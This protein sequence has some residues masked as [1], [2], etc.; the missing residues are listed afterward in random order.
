[1]LCAGAAAA[2]EGTAAQQIASELA[3]ACRVCFLLVLSLAIL[4]A[5]V[6]GCLMG[7]SAGVNV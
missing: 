1:V 6:P 2:D 7:W 5:V 4:R 3:V